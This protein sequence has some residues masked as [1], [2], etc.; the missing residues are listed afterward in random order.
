MNKYRFSHRAMAT[1]FE[2]IINCPDQEYSEGMA[3][4]IWKRIDILENEL[5]RYNPNSDISKINSLKIGERTTLSEH[6]FNCLEYSQTLYDLTDGAFNI[7]S[8][9]LYNCWLNPDKS[10]KNPTTAEIELAAQKS[11]ISNIILYDDYS[12]GIKK[13]GT[14]IDLGAFGKGYSIDV[15]YEMLKYWGIESAFLSA[16]QSSIRAFSNNNYSEGWDISISNQNNYD[17]K[18]YNCKLRNMSIGSSGLSKGNHIIDTKKMKPVEEKRG[19]WVF[20]GSAAE[21]DALSTAFMILDYDLIKTILKCL[22]NTGV[23]IIEPNQVTKVSDIVMLGE[24]GCD[25]NLLLA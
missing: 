1:V 22:E 11:D 8:G 25:M 6:S 10:L 9:A 19:V 21:A 3:G 12:V 14:V 18:V 16:G 4:E 13:E 7:A 20:T 5:S 2:L 23:I 15:A 17:Q 24:I